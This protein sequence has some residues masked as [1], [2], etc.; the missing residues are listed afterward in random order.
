MAGWATFWHIIRAQ[1]C[2]L[3]VN[4]R[5]GELYHRQ[6]DYYEEDL[7]SRPSLVD[8]GARIFASFFYG[9]QC[10][11]PFKTELTVY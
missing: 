10:V 11:W 2:H 3:R 9:S 6:T 5:S 4:V 1:Q 7:C 8:G